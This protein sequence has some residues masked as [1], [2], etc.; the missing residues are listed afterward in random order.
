MFHL[1]LSLFDK[2]SG[3][4]C[5][6]KI[7]SRPES[8]WLAFGPHNFTVCAGFRTKKS[9]EVLGS[10]QAYKSYYYCIP[11]M[12]HSLSHA[13]SLGAYI[14][15]DKIKNKEPPHTMLK[16]PWKYPAHF[17]K[18][19]KHR[20]PITLSKNGYPPTEFICFIFFLNFFKLQL[21]YQLS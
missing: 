2:L 13:H 6:P 14:R 20:I 4:F 11:F 10:L 7:P 9:Y 18:L 12:G 19:S 17:H 16:T 15:T 3:L 1:G 8:L 21:H 5:F